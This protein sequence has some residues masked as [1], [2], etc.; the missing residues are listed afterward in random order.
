MNMAEDATRDTHCRMGEQETIWAATGV[1]RSWIEKH[2][3]LRAL[4]TD[5]KNAYKRE[6][7]ERERLQGKRLRRSSDACASVWRSA[8]SRQIHRKRKIAWSETTENIKIAW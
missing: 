6:P 7:T 5:W 2:G 8:E 3:V 4:Y 1:L